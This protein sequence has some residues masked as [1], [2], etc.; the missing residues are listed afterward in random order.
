MNRR[1]EAWKLG[2][3]SD[4][5]CG[6]DKGAG[7]ITWCLLGVW[8]RVAVQDPWVWSEKGKA[9]RVAVDAPSS[10]QSTPFTFSGAPF[11]FH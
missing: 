3:G 7:L 4:S 10:L 9:E 2:L 11:C 1:R 8:W 5:A 6:S